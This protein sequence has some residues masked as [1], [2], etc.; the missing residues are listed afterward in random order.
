MP[1]PQPLP[2][3]PADL[4][5][6]IRDHVRGLVSYA[7]ALGQDAEELFAWLHG[8]FAAA[9]KP[10]LAT[11]KPAEAPSSAAPTPAA[12]IAVGS[13]VDGKEIAGASG[14][15][16]DGQTLRATPAP[17][18]AATPA[19]PGIPPVQVFP[20]PNPTPPASSPDK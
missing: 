14:P 9:P 15:I 13:S 11:A 10:F 20:A 5:D 3:T 12:P 16:A 2:D 8:H 17:R 19:V 6:H 4:P 1:T 18:P 7:Q